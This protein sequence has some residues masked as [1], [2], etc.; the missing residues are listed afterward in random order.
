MITRRKGNSQGDRI[1]PAYFLSQTKEIIT[2]PKDSNFI[3]RLSDFIVI[4]VPSLTLLNSVVLVLTR[5]IYVDAFSKM[6]HA[7][8]IIIFIGFMSFFPALASTKIHPI[9]R[10]ISCIVIIPTA[11]MDFTGIASTPNIQNT[12]Q[13]G[14]NIY[15]LVWYDDIFDS[16]A[17]Y[18]LLECKNLSTFCYRV[19]DNL[20]KV[21]ISPAELIPNND[22]GELDVFINGALT[23]IYGDRSY[24]F[25]YGDSVDYEDHIYWA[26]YTDQ[27]D[28]LIYKFGMCDLET[29]ISCKLLQ[30]YSNPS[31]NHMNLAVDNEGKDLFIF[32][33]GI[34]TYTF[35][36][37]TRS[38]DLLDSL[39]TQHSLG[40]GY[41]STYRISTYANNNKYQYIL[42]ECNAKYFWC[43]TLPFGYSTFE[44]TK[45]LLKIDESKKELSVYIDDA[46]IFTYSKHPRCYVEGCEILK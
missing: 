45:P 3:R 27:G 2:M 30:S 14:E 6:A 5:G 15:H 34:L 29:K 19:S 18:Y 38:Y 16:K 8:G 17:Y 40:N 24:N 26:V 46:L 42:Y 44:K 41:P 22:K 36:N 35:N 9:W 11:C 39:E 33:D 20:N 21:A 4:V 13:L 10:V 12:A 25:E 1:Y 32:L 37:A 23:Y 43:Q 28:D 31:F 7:W